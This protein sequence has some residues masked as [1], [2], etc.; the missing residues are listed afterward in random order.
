MV[1]VALL[2][3]VSEYKSGFKPLLSAIADIQSMQRVLQEQLT[4][5][6]SER[7]VVILDCCYSGA[8]A[9]GGGISKNL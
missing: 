3:G 5:S 7:Q 8:I 9:T 6:R 4:D 2:V 1:K